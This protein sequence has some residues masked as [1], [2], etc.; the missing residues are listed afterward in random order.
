MGFRLVISSGSAQELH[1]IANGH[2][3]R[4]M[5]CTWRITVRG[6]GIFDAGPSLDLGL[7]PKSGREMTRLQMGKGGPDV[8]PP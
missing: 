4:W 1:L 5:A 7:Q 6:R 2:K 8:N 3:G